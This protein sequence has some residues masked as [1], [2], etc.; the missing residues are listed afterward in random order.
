MAKSTVNQSQ[1]L[2]CALNE[3]GPPE[4]RLLT[5]MT[6]VTTETI[7]TT[8]MTGLRQRRRGSSRRKEP[9]TADLISPDCHILICFSS[10]DVSSLENPAGC[11][12]E[13]F[14]HGPENEGG[15]KGE[16]PDDDDDPGEHADE[17]GACRRERG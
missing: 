3:K 11:E 1:M 8:N 9:V 5:E 14:E 6:V 4:K 10:M 13:L 2:I 15:E 17:E 16:G 7:S 12:Q